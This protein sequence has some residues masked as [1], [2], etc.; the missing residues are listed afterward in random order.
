MYGMKAERDH[1]TAWLRI[2][3]SA[4]DTTILSVNREAKKQSDELVHCTTMYY[5]PV[6]AHLAEELVAKMPRGVD[7]VVHFVQ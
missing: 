3:A 5:H 2:F 7:W 6:P 1:W 4:S